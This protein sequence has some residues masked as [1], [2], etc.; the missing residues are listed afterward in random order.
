MASVMNFWLA[1][2]AAEAV[3]IEPSKNAAAAICTTSFLLMF[4]RSSSEAPEGA[5][6]Q[7]SPHRPSSSRAAGIAAAGRGLSA[8]RPFATGEL[9]RTGRWLQ[10]ADLRSTGGDGLFYCF[11]AE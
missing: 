11:P 1:L 5:A 10:P 2:S 7:T 6:E 4:P 9:A 3:A 8:R